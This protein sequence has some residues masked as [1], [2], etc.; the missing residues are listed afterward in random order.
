M[1]T[2]FAIVALVAFTVLGVNAQ[3]KSMVKIADLPKAITENLSA[4]HKDWKPAEAFKVDTK[5]IVSYEV[6]VKKGTAEEKLLYDK[7]GKLTK[8]EPIAMRSAPK[9]QMSTVKHNPTRSTTVKPVSSK[10]VSHRTSATTG[11]TAKPVKK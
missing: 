8:T 3:T 5:G 1:K 9:R 10:S 7:N 2:L 6:I 11:T 4:Q